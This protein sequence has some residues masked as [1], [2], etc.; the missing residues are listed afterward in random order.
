MNFGRIVPQVNMH[1]LTESD[2]GYDVIF[3]N[4][5]AVTSY[6]EKPKATLLQNRAR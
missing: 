2:F 5:V 1:Q 4:M 3:K 6:H